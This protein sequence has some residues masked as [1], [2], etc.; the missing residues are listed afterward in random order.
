MTVGSLFAG[1]GGFDLAAE[2]AGLTV[3]WQ[4]EIDPFCQKV[5]EKHWPHVTR[6]RAWVC[7]QWRQVPSVSCAW[8][9][10]CSGRGHHRD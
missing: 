3:K 8:M 1:I 6:R 2:R 10:A 4:V 7:R 5:L 9:E